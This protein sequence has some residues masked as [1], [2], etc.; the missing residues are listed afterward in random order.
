MVNIAVARMMVSF[1]EQTGGRH[2]S[3]DEAALGK[4]ENG[5]LWAWL[6]G[7]AARQRAT[8]RGGLTAPRA[9]V[10]PGA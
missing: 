1:V 9:E 6:L 4:A 7:V 10:G 2:R 3:E 8:A 5:G